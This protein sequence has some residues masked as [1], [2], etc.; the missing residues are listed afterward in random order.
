MYDGEM[1]TIALALTRLD[2]P[3]LIGVAKSRPMTLIFM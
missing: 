3:Y 2:F 1:L